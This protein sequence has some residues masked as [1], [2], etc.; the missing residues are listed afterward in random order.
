MGSLM[1][2]ASQLDCLSLY[3]LLYSPPSCCDKTEERPV[4]ETRDKESPGDS[5]FRCNKR[6]LAKHAFEGGKEE[7]EIGQNTQQGVRENK[8]KEN[9]DIPL[10][11]LGTFGAGVQRQMR[12]RPLSGSCGACCCGGSGGLLSAV[13]GVFKLRSSIRGPSVLREAALFLVRG[14][15][16]RRGESGDGG[17]PV[18][19]GFLSGNVCLPP[20]PLAPGLDD[21][22]MTCDLLLCP[23]WLS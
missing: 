2:A 11:G 6:E 10:R 15:A 22:D 18:R 7:A 16:E 21:M 13:V 9:E 14:P 1:L 23:L 4:Y 12:S 19:S 3:L 8:S 5:K 17:S 20:A